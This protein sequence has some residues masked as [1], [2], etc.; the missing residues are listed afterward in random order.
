MTSKTPHHVVKAKAVVLRKSPNAR[1][2]VVRRAAY[3]D[4]LRTLERRGDWVKVTH[5]GGGTGWVARRLV[6][7]W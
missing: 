6:W 2:P 5:E 7:G 4:V 3:G 1:S